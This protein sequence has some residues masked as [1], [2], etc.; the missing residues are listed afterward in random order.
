MTLAGDATKTIVPLQKSSQQYTTPF[1]NALCCTNTNDVACSLALG[2]FSC[3]R[4]NCNDLTNTT[5]NPQGITQQFSIILGTDA[6][7]AVQM[8]VFRPLP[9]VLLLG[10]QGFQH[11]AST[12]QQS[13]TAAASKIQQS[14]TAAAMQQQQPRHLRNI[15][16]HGFNATATAPWNVQRSNGRGIYRTKAPRQLCTNNGR[17]IYETITAIAST[18]QQWPRHLRNSNDNQQ[19]PW[20]LRYNNQQWPRLCDNNSHVIYVTLPATASMQHS[21]SASECTKEKWQRNLQNKSAAATMQE[22]WP[23][24]LRNNNGHGIYKTAMAAA[25]TKQQ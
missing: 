8:V 17:N 5:I 20:H 2:S 25:S 22:Q 19:W 21:N 13:T 11:A 24:H 14:T 7:E 3:L 10:L 12:I 23:R 9:R 6:A 18:K 4:F 16:G 15:A 1:S